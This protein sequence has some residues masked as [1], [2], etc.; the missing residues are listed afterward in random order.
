MLTNQWTTDPENLLKGQGRDVSNDIPDLVIV[1][2]G[3]SIGEGLEVQS[4]GR[5]SPCKK[6]LT[7]ALKDHCSG[8]VR[9]FF[10]A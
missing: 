10:C 1:D 5:R 3:G 6:S 9:C 7:A 4:G 2:A 8:P